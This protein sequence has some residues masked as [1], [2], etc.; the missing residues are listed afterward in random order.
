MCRAGLV[1]R[2]S[3]IIKLSTRDKDGNKARRKLQLETN[4]DVLVAFMERSDDHPTWREMRESDCQ[5]HH[6]QFKYSFLADRNMDIPFHLLTL[7][8][9]SEMKAIMRIAHQMDASEGGMNHLVDSANV[10]LLLQRFGCPP[11]EITEVSLSTNQKVD[12]LQR[13]EY[14]SGTAIGNASCEDI[15]GSDDAEGVQ[16]T[17]S[18]TPFSMHPMQIRTFEITCAI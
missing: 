12:E 7:M 13:L 11:K 14:M 8:K 18:D 2:G 4:D 16:S 10:Y 3:H 6:H 9:V 5:H 15:F 17:Q 1:A